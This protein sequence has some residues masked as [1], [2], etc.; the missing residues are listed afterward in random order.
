MPEGE[1]ATRWNKRRLPTLPN[2]VNE[3][4]PCLVP[5]EGQIV[6]PATPAIEEHEGQ[7]IDRKKRTLEHPRN[8]G[9]GVTAAWDD[10]QSASG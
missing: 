10:P 1:T 7:R 6:S 5:L 4:Y 8:Q 9:W 2:D 3:H